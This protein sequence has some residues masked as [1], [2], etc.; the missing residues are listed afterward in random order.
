MDRSLLVAAEAGAP[1]HTGRSKVVYSLPGDRCLIRLVPSLTSFTYRREELVPGT[2]VLR[3]DFYERAGAVL[4]QA[5]VRTVFLERVDDT[6][7]VAQYVPSPPFEVIVKNVATGSTV[8]KYPGLFPEGHRF[9]TPV[10]KLDYRTDPEDQPIAEDYLREYG[11][12]VPDVKRVALQANAALRDW[13]AP[14]DLLDFCVI[15]GV[16]PDGDYWVNSEVSPDAMRLRAPD[17]SCLDKDLFRNGADGAEIVQV[18]K[19]L[20]HSLG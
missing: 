5:D 11:M 2:D 15:L 3:L 18:W 1:V 12:S 13:L 9:T 10:V 17:G 14:R 16:G 20:V 8:R 19:E 7:Y 4:R 6:A